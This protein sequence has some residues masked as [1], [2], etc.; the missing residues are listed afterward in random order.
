MTWNIQ[1]KLKNLEKEKCSL[2]DL[3]YDEKTET[4]GNAKCTL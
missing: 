1:G 4:H 2:W 3:E